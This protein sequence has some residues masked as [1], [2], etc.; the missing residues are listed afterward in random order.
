MTDFQDQ[1]DLSQC[2]WPEWVKEDF[3]A[4][5]GNGCVGHVVTAENERV[6]VWHLN[7]PPGERLPFHTHVLDY[8]WTCV[9]GGRAKSHVALKGKFEITEWSLKPGSTRFENYPVGT[10]KI[11]DLQNTGDKDLVF[12]TV[13]FLNSENKAL[14]IPDSVRM[15]EHDGVLHAA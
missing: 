8:F 4:R 12:V 15:S 7:V 11:H 10:F 9:S 2:P 6:R 13:E 14:A 1:V 5:K 3:C